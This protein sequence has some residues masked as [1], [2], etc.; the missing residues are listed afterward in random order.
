MPRKYAGPLLP[1]KKSAYVRGA[2]K[3]QPRKSKAK[4]GLNK[5][6]KNQVK[7]IVAS[8]KELKYCPSW[9]NYDVYNPDL[10]TDT[11]LPAI[12]GAVVLPN[13][14]NSGHNVATIVG[15]QTGH[16][17]N[18]ASQAL[19]SALTASGQGPCM[20]A[21]GGFGMEK[22]DTSTTIDG[23][24]AY[25]HSSKVT[26]QINGLVAGNNAGTVNDAVT[27]LCFRILHLRTKKD[28]TG[29]TP[30]LTGDVFRDMV[31]QNG[32]FMSDMT[33]RQLMNDWSINRDR[34]EV[35]HDIRFKLSE[36]I[37]P[38]YAGTVANRLVNNLP[39]PTEK[40]VTLWLNKTKKKLRFNG[41]DNGTTN[42]YEPLN[43]DFVDYIFVLCD[44]EYIDSSDY[45]STQK[46]WVVTTQGQTKFRDC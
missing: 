7:K 9:I 10:Y 46:R 13:V 29:T 37:Q 25:L 34:F 31:N 28:A 35:K 11:Q 6:E 20:N 32:G 41:Q 26:L 42:A 39:H 45:S 27:P 16:Y 21:L 43:Y 23:D 1:G 4:V 40:R 30:S 2:R 44:R 17:L 8:R 3:N 18:T 14:Y 15:F 19:D 36:P 38:A 33:Q 5:V 12:S 22:G 24:Y